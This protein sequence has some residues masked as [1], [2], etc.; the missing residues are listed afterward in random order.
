MTATRTGPK[1]L[2]GLSP[3][4]STS[5]ARSAA[6]IAAVVHVAE[7]RQRVVRRRDDVAPGLVEVFVASGSNDVLVD[8][9]E[10][11]HGDGLG[12]GV[13]PLVHQR[14]RGGQ[15]LALLVGD[16]LVDARRPLR[17]TG[18]PAR[19]CPRAEIRRMW[20]ALIASHFFM[21][22]R[23][24]FGLTRRMSNASAISSIVKTSRSSAMPQPS[25]AR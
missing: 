11:E 10:A 1:A 4:P 19:S 3:S 22:K 23:A 20:A 14:H 25:R 9:Q 21:S 15:Q 5:A 13:D 8:E 24:G 2:R 17:G 7:R 16:R 18:S 6:S 12:Q